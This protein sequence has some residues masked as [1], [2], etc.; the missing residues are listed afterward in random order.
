[1]KTGIISLNRT[2]RIRMI[3]FDSTFE[4]SLIGQCIKESF[5]EE[6]PSYK[7]YYGAPE[8]KLQGNPFHCSGQEA[9]KTRRLISKMLVRIVLVLNTVE[10][11]S[12]K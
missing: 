1:M 2:D 10:F 7:E 9:I 6:A 4:P 5:Q 8:F 12:G 11:C 3:G